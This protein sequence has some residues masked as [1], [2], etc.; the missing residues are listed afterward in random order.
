MDFL[1]ENL[2][3]QHPP[4]VCCPYS[5]ILLNKSGKPYCYNFSEQIQSIWNISVSGMQKILIDVLKSISQ[6]PYNQLMDFRLPSIKNK[7]I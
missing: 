4:H 1:Y 3:N 6:M 2:V 5:K 7:Q